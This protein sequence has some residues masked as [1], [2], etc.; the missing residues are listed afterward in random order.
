MAGAFE[1]NDIVERLQR[2]SNIPTDADGTIATRTT[3]LRLEAGAGSGGDDVGRD[4]KDGWRQRMVRTVVTAFLRFRS[5][6]AAVVAKLG[7]GRAGQV[8]S[9]GFVFLLRDMTLTS[10]RN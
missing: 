7:L 6:L 10:D 4:D 9:G 2:W 3:R 5:I 1:R 8:R